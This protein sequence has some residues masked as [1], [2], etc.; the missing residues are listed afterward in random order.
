MKSY[1][2]EICL[3]HYWSVL[4]QIGFPSY[5]KKSMKDLVAIISEEKH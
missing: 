4:V 1:I 2:E 5:S 3:N